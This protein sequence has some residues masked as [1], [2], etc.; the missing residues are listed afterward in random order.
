MQFFIITGASRGIGEA[1]ATQLLDDNHHIFCISRT[2][3][4][5][6][7]ELAKEKNNRISYHPFDLNNLSGIDQLFEELFNTIQHESK[8]D[9]VHLINN[10]G[11]LSP[12][13]PIELNSADSIIENVNIN[14][15]APMIF[16]SNFIKHTLELN[17]DKRIMNISSASAKYLL[18]SQSCYSTSKAGLDSFSKS[19]SLEQLN[20]EY[21]A[22]VVS[23]YPGMIDTQL[24]AEI[25]SVSSETFP[26]VDQFIQIA[27]EGKLQTPEY[28]ADKLIEIL[29]SED[30]GSTVVIEEL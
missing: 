8:I 13:A 17:I 2:S 24:Q 5:R 11:M 30:F 14:L 15:L 10:A 16:T 28:T 7:I 22:K 18:P 9:A 21:P 27:Q 19:V 29:F 20:K 12:V 23:V 25:R 4:H 6:L 26:Y 1:L 3:N